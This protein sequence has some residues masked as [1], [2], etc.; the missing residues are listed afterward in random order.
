MAR[1]TI[2]IPDDLKKRMDQLEERVNWSRVA[3][4]AF[5]SVIDNF[6][7]Y[8]KAAAKAET[9]LV[10]IVGTNPLLVSR[11]PV[12]RTCCPVGKRT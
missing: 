1:T 5:E 6:P 10:R 3:A 8:Q 4:L 12:K 11:F 2:S 9:M 7:A